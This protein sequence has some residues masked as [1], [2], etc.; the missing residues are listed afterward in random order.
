MLKRRLSGPAATA[1]LAASLLVGCGSADPASSARAGAAATPKPPLPPGRIAFR[2]W[3]DDAKTHGAIFTVRTDGSGERQLTNPN[4]G[5]DDY[6]DWSP[7]GT[8]IAYEHCPGEG[9]PCSVWTVDA[10]GGTPHQVRFRCRLRPICD[11]A[12][13]AWTP[14]GKL[15]VTLAQGR[16]RT[17]G[18]EPQIQQSAIVQLDL[19]TGSRRTL[20]QRTNWAGDAVE[21]QASP[22][23]HTVIYTP[24]NSARSKPPFGQAVFAVGSDGSHRHRVTAWDLGG[25][26]HPVFSP[27]GLILFRSY[28]ADE[29]RQSDF[30]TVRPDSSGLRRL[31]HFKKGTLVTSASYSPDGAWIVYG[32]DGDGGADLHVM[33]ADGTG[34]RV[35]T[36]TKWWDSAPDW[37]PRP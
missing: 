32:S 17:I 21:A 9:D 33:R 13:P 37:E 36:S 19:R 29:G 22:D 14:D 3:L 15:L 11:A 8:L 1:L 18:G 10:D 7:D 35:L 20:Y 12:A 23:G 24:V 30:W 28:E 26:D 31:T 25:G 34:S 5:A 6:P 4:S 16:V 2:R 27:D